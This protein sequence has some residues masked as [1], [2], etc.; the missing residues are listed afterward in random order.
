VGGSKGL[1]LTLRLDLRVG[2]AAEAKRS[3]LVLGKGEDVKGGA[4][5]PVNS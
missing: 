2:V 3:S 5:M 1:T 4:G